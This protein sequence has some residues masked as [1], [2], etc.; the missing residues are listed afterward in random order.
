MSQIN[1]QSETLLPLTEAAKH[2]PRRNGKKVHH[3]TLYR[4]ATK[5]VRG[6]VLATIM[7]GG[8]RYTS[9]E[10]LGRFTTVSRPRSGSIAVDGLDAVNRALD[11]AGL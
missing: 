3:S 1:L 7:V 5:G 9:I 6:R 10:A 11:E 8:I 4:W 2:L